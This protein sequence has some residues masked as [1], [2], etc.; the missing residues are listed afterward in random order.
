MQGVDPLPYRLPELLAETSRP[1]V[2]CEGEK[3][4]DNLARS[5]PRQFRGSFDEAEKRLRELA[6]AGLGEMA[7]PAHDGPGRPK[8]YVFTLRDVEPMEPEP[9]FTETRE[10]GG[11]WFRFHWFQ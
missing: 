3:D 5:G 11:F 10:S 1:V 9:E 8:G 2:V 4:A 7:V 6:E